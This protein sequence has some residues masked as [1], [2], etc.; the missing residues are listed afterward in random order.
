MTRRFGATDG[1]NR[2]RT[3]LFPCNSWRV[4]AKTKHGILMKPVGI[5]KARFICNA[6]VSSMP[7]PADC[8]GFFLG[9]S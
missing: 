2:T 5:L 9:E 8:F 1:T 6:E 4:K 3:C 7:E